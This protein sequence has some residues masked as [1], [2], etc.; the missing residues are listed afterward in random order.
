MTCRHIA[1]VTFL[2]LFLAQPAAAQHLETALEEARIA[3]KNHQY[4][5]VVEILTPYNSV[6]DEESRYITAAEIGRAYF[7]LG[8]YQESHRAFRE[9][10]RLRSDRIETAIYL[11][12]TAYLMG[13]RE[14]AV[15]ILRE[16]LKSGAEDLYLA[17]TLP[18][19]RR[20]LADPE[21]RAL[22][23]EF[24]V[25]VPVDLDPPGFL[26]ATLGDGRAVDT[27]GRRC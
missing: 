14:Q 5:K 3:A 17:V 21:V 7:H 18:G 20:F 8:R 25:P 16:V 2:G 15:A 24:A 9:A 4:D 1:L 12:A 26:G 23:A 13:E 6:P 11:Q 22:L 27:G 19:E 10:V